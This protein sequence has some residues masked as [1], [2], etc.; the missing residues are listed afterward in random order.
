MNIFSCRS[1]IRLMP[2]AASIFLL[3]AACLGYSKNPTAL[4]ELTVESNRNKIV[5]IL[6]YMRDYSSLIISYDDTIFPFREKLVDFML[7]PNERIKFKGWSMPRTLLSRSYYHFTNSNGRDSV[8]DES[9]LHFSWS[10]WVGMPPLNSLPDRLSYRNNGTDT[11]MGKYSPCIVWD[12][13]DDRV[14]VDV[15]ALAAEEGKKWCGAFK[16]FWNN[17]VDFDYFKL[18]FTYDNVLS[19]DLSA[20]DLIGYSYSIASSGRGHELQRIPLNRGPVFVSTDAQLW[21]L[22]REFLT[23][24]EAKIWEDYRFDEESVALFEPA[25]APPLSPEIMAL[26]E[27][28]EGINKQEVRLSL[29]PDER[30]IS[31]FFGKKKPNLG[32]RALTLFKQLTG[33]TLYKSN[34]NAKDQWREFKRKQIRKNKEKIPANP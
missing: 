12:K 3:G 15:N 23:K 21:M 27:R 32:D 1:K 17:K 18:S 31:K 26:V 22:D 16:G 8:S 24:K 33:I 19:A 20:S 10:D 4:P 14:R 25:D 9:G 11:L 2:G 29:P 13:K 7:V 30:L 28:V 5:H 34:K 6:A